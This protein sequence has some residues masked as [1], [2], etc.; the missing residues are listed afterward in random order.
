MK[1]STVYDVP[2]GTSSGLMLY[3]K[4]IEVVHQLEKTQVVE[5]VRNYSQSYEKLW[6]HDRVHHE[7]NQLCS[8]HT[9]HE[10]RKIK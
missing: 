6:I 4:S 9:L 2:C 7:I 10:V 8:N 1:T 3:F 5:T